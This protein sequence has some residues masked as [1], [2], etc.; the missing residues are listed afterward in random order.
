MKGLMGADRLNTWALGE[1]T[2]ENALR[3]GSRWWGCRDKKS[4]GEALRSLQSE[5]QETGLLGCLVDAAIVRHIP[6]VVL[7]AFTVVEAAWEVS[8]AVGNQST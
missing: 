3:P 8:G 4:A 7:V 2:F 6:L 1:L 5:G